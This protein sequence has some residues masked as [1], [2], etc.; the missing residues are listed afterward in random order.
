MKTSAILFDRAYRGDWPELENFLAA[1]VEKIRRF[2]EDITLVSASGR[3]FPGVKSKFF[4]TSRDFLTY[5]ESLQ[6]EAVLLLP[7]DSPLL[8]MQLTEKMLEEHRKWVFDYSYP[9]NLPAGLLPEILS[10]AVV[11]FIRE[12]LP[13]NLGMFSRSVRELFERDLSSYDCN[14]MITE[15]RLIKHQVEFIPDTPNHYELLKA[16]LAGAGKEPGLEGLE[17]FLMKNPGAMRH[18]PT[19]Y[20]IELTREGAIGL[21]RKGPDRRGEMPLADFKA[22]LAEISRFSGNPWVSLGLYGEPLF[23]S[24]MPGIIT[25]L[26]KYP[27]MTFIIESKGSSFT[28]AVSK[29]LELPNV[30]FILDLSAARDEAFEV[31]KKDAKSP[32]PFTSLSELEKK[33]AP[34]ASN[35]RFYLQF[36]RTASNENELFAFYERF[37]PFAERIIVKK[38]DTWGGELRNLLSVDLSPIDRYPCLHLKHDLVILTDGRVPLCRED[39]DAET[40]GK[41]LFNDGLEA[42]WDA[43]KTAYSAQWQNDFEHPALCKNCDEWWVFNH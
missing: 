11:P 31:L 35:P 27:D 4:S 34:F 29:L 23:Y 15:S 24:D 39:L 38:P 37:R 6:A 25:E 26:S 30:R 21:P 17:Q 22:L 36:T 7:C 9:E 33:L 32:L 10:S 18:R 12:S 42:C 3:T 41:N 43:L 40:T 14:I 19:Y 20:E 5:A 2:T 8:D 1:T 13:E 28:E 16:A